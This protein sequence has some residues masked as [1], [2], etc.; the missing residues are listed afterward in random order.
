VANRW[1]ASA[2]VDSLKRR[3][4]IP[5]ADETFNATDFYAL[6][7]EETRTYI[8]PILREVHEEFLHVRYDSD[9][10]SGQAA[11]PFP[12]RCAAEA[13]KMILL[14][15]NADGSWGPP[16][17]RIEPEKA[18]GIGGGGVGSYYLEDDCAVLSP[19]PNAS[20]GTLR[21]VHFNRP[22]H[23]VAATAAAEVT[24]INTGTGEVTLRLADQTAGVPATFTSSELYDLIKGT[25]GFRTLAIDQAATVAS[26][27][28][29]FATLP[30][31]L[32]VGDFVALAGQSPVAQVPAEFHPLLAQRVMFVCLDAMSPRESAKAELT[33]EK[34]EQ[35]V[36]GMFMN[37]TEAQPRYLHNFSAP[38]WRRTRVRR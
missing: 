27:I 5:T 20:G 31:R 7:D 33:L 37:R 21:F 34:M 24:T 11:Y 35:K 17:A 32:A 14:D 30:S 16:L 9:I 25:P 2:L 3:G 22:N 8:L 36:R 23:V 38:G 15:P 26:N 29:T 19:T 10:V 12:P 18:V 6:I 1:L 28:L 13:V 4:L